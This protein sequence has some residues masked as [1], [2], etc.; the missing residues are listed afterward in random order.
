MKQT[1]IS[2]CISYTISSKCS[3]ITFVHLSSCVLTFSI[4]SS[5]FCKFFFFCIYFC[6]RC[7]VYKVRITQHSLA[8]CDFF[9]RRAPVL[10][11]RS[12]SFSLS[13]KVFQRHIYNLH[14]ILL[15]ILHLHR[16]RLLFS[17]TRISFANARFT[18]DF[19]HALFYTCCMYQH[20]CLRCKGLFCGFIRN[21]HLC[22][23]IT[24]TSYNLFKAFLCFLASGKFLVF[25][26]PAS[27]RS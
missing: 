19:L 21:V 13:I 15:R 9:W 8:S 3:F 16:F 27:R 6:F 5:Y 1:G 24:D 23:G 26:I 14:R 25:C 18:K 11:R 22:S 12:I 20:P 17:C 4:I 7:F 2:Y 10:F